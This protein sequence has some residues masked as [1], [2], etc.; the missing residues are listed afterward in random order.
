MKIYEIGT[1]YTPIPAQMGAATE[2]VVEELTRSLIKN[3]ED[4]EIIDI[5]AQQ[6]GKL[7][8]PLT[9]VNVPSMFTKTDV[10]LGL[11]HKLKR[12]V[13]SLALAK[14]LK[15]IIK[16]QSQSG[17][18]IV[19]HFHNQYNLYFFLKTVSKKLRAKV[20]TAY[21][22]H[23]YIWSGAWEEIENTVR[24]KY[25]QEIYCLQ[26]ADMVF[27]LNDI[28]AE[29]FVKYFNADKTK[30]H[31]IAN[32]VNVERYA[33]LP[34]Q[35][36]EELKAQNGLTGK[37]VVFQV[38]S[39]CERKNQMGTLQMLCDYLKTNG[40]V[41]YMYAGGIIDNE[42]KQKID[43]FAAQN[44]IAEQVKYAGELT[45]GKQLNEYYNIADCCAFT[46]TLEAFSL[47]IIEA[48]AA[49]VPLIVGDNLRFDLSGG[50][51]V[52]NTPQDFAQQVDSVLKNG[53]QSTQ[54]R[55]QVINDNSWDAV[56]KIYK[57]FFEI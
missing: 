8:I 53:R 11:V 16:T 15:K 26:N 14:K 47:V 36:V 37:K 6:R 31:L 3:G 13:Y 55:Q 50:Y 54:G 19:L 46:S 1:G 5:K 32:G 29:K 17:Q 10:S 22:V 21:T 9:E 42:Y 18:K 49:G 7:E 28:S 2:I 52:F 4:A 25:F 45:P 27:A 57:D 51:T 34:Q 30:I 56:A 39:V 12:V 23:S 40:D 35:K 41:V 33:P 48:V 38:G 44:N 24:K 20:T 43:D